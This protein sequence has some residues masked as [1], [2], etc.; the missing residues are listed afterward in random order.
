MTAISINPNIWSIV[1]GHLL[2]TRSKKEQAA[3]LF[4]RYEADLSTIQIIDHSPR[5]AA[6]T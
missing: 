4:G 1:S 5:K 6:T 3:F 2:Q